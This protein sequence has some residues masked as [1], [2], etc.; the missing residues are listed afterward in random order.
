M[1]LVFVQDL[2]LIYAILFTMSIVSSF[3]IPAQSVA[4]RTLTP[5]AGL[6]VA[7]GLMSQ[8][9]QGSQIIA[10][11]VAGELVQLVGANSCF[12]FDSFSFF[13]S[14]ALVVTLRIDRQSSGA[15]A[16]G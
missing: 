2:Y 11:A 13:F 3:F 6:I 15:G 16:T 4:V 9:Q 8:A 10:P 12:L 14:A 7:N 1:A 5:M